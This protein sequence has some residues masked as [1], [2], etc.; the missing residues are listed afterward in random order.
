MSESTISKKCS[1]KKHEQNEAIFYCQECKIYMCN[2]CENYHSELF[3]N[4]KKYKLDTN[5]NI[6][7]IFTGFCKEENHNNPLLFLCKS[8]NKL[9]C[10][11]CLSKIKKKGNGQHSDC[12]VCLIE[13]IKDEKKNKLK[14]NIDNL[15]KLSKV[16]ESSINKFNIIAEKI[17]QGQ[18][19]PL[20]TQWAFSKHYGDTVVPDL[21]RWTKEDKDEY[22]K[23]IL[24][25]IQ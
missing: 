10:G 25:N 23:F 8:H 2:K 3:P 13:E 20:C 6:N 12:D 22:N 19:V 21:T 18:F 4:H 16:F 9:C 7:E 14:E 17:K 1:L 11:A 5:I 24:Q 15:E